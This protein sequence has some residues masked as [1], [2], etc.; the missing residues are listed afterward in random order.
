MKRAKCLILLLL[1]SIFINTNIAEASSEYVIGNGGVY[2]YNSPNYVK[3]TTYLRVVKTGWHIVEY[4]ISKDGFYDLDKIT[5]IR[6]KILGSSDGY[7]ETIYQPEGKD[8]PATRFTDFEAGLT[9]LALE[10]WFNPG[11]EDIYRGVYISKV[12]IEDED[13]SQITV[14]PE[15]GITPLDPPSAPTITLGE[16]GLTHVKISWGAVNG[17]TS[18]KIYK[19]GL[20]IGTATGT[21]YTYNFLTPGTQY[22]FKIRAVNDGGESAFSN[23]LSVSTNTL[24]APDQV[25]VTDKGWYH[26]KVS[27]VPV[28]GADGYRLYVN[29]VYVGTTTGTNH[30]FSELDEGTL[31]ELGVAPYIGE[32]EGGVKYI[33]VGTQGVSQFDELLYVLQSYFPDT[34]NLIKQLCQQISSDL[35]VIS[36]NVGVIAE[37]TGSIKNDMRSMKDYFTTPRT[38]PPLQ[39]EPLPSVSFEPTIPDI[40]EPALDPYIYDRPDPV[41][42]EPVESPEPL[43][44]A[45]DPV[46]M[47]HDD[48]I[49][50]D[51]PKQPTEAIVRDEPVPRDPVNMDPPLQQDPVKM[52]PPLAQDPV[53]LD[54][55][56]SQDP[57]RS[58]EPPRGRDDPIVVDP[59]LTPTDPLTPETP[60]N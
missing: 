59:P 18:Y 41:I 16:K 3:S 23:A 44:F 6:K 10:A 53:A 47:P 36:T 43:P 14:F 5:A 28:S 8:L 21:S 7:W 26:A 46:T 52:D 31:Y 58:M 50:S 54:P 22:E 17:A 60:K 30:E 25:Q 2:S 38:A 1:L 9:E 49:T 57:I 27:W 33:I 13:G 42:P 11:A 51:S 48:P 34:F 15:A 40:S 37:N 56:V 35:P 32:H 55:P 19:N 12:V 29:S 24:P 45:P 4:T 39:P 20:F